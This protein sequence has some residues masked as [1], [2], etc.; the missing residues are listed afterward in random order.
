MRHTLSFALSFCSCIVFAQLSTPSGTVSTNSSGTGIGIGQ[1]APEHQ[2]HI[3]YNNNASSTNGLLY[4]RAATANG[5]GGT[6]S[7]PFGIRLQYANELTSYPLTTVFDL[8]PSG[9]LQVGDLSAIPPAELGITRHDFSQHL[10][11][12]N[13][14][15]TLRFS[16]QQPVISWSGSESLRFKN[17]NFSGTTLLSL[18]DNQRVG[19]NTE[20]PEA[21]L[22][23][24]NPSPNNSVNDGTVNGLLIN[25]GG[26][27]PQN[28]SLLVK[29]A[30]LPEEGIFSVSDRGYVGIG[31]ENGGTAPLYIKNMDADVSA[32]N[33]TSGM[34]IQHNSMAADKYSIRVATGFSSTAFTVSDKGWICSNGTPF[35]QAALSPLHIRST[36]ANNNSDGTVNGLLIENFNANTDGN[37]SLKIDTEL[38]EVFSVSDQGNVLIKNVWA[39]NSGATGQLNGLKILTNGYRGHDYAF[40]IW[41]GNTNKMFSV[42]QSGHVHIGPDLNFDIP[43]S[44]LYRLYVQD[45]IRTERVRVDVASLNGWAD[46]VFE[47]DYQMM[48]LAELE[49]YIQ[50]N[51]HLP[52]VP[53]AQQVVEEGIDLAEMNKVLLEK[54]EELTLRNIYLD[55]R[56]DDLEKKMAKTID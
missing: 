10:G 30:W 55:K 25:S 45:G 56:L 4:L 34:M 22:H 37:Y 33:T 23:I 13:G 40:E 51:K 17:G 36:T 27:F 32:P 26:H 18:H 54:V 50:K 49:S 2:L 3:K 38:G 31:A 42:S 28:Y 46:Y 8:S 47:E 5:L 12:Y 15:N 20:S 19:I 14:E 7:Q 6:V 24:D 52:G 11:L 35:P 16:A 9:A 39:T 43:D 29:S 48:P 41:T 44:D 1:T 21:P 53:S